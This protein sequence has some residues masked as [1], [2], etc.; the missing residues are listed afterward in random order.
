MCNEKLVRNS[1]NTGFGCI[2]YNTVLIHSFVAIGSPDTLIRKYCDMQ[3]QLVLLTERSGNLQTS[4]AIA[5]S[6]LDSESRELVDIK[7]ELAMEKAN[8]KIKNEQCQK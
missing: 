5:D 3:Q 7:A 1:E 4:L 8:S 6:K 2:Y